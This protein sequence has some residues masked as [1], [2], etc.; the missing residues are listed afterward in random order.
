MK[1][2]IRAHFLLL[3]Y[4]VRRLTIATTINRVFC[5]F[6]PCFASL[7]CSNANSGLFNRMR[8]VCG[9]RQTKQK[10]EKRDNHQETLLKR[11]WSNNY[12]PPVSMKYSYYSFM[13]DE[14]CSLKDQTYHQEKKDPVCLFSSIHRFFSI[15]N[16]HH[17]T[18]YWQGYCCV[19]RYEPHWKILIQQQ[20]KIIISSNNWCCDGLLLVLRR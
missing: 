20:P 8:V 4:L 11:H 12:S 7:P 1:Q 17:C 16:T 15:V 3:H 13:W 14:D 2:I 19:A 9:R 5:L 18:P 6:C 10:K